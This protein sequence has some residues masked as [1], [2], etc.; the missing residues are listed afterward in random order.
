MSASMTPC[1][2]SWIRRASALLVALSAVTRA[3][4]AEALPPT[5]KRAVPEFGSLILGEFGVVIV[6]GAKPGAYGRILPAEVLY[7]ESRRDSAGPAYGAWAAPVE[8]WASER[9]RGV[10][11][12]PAML[13]G[14]IQGSRWAVLMGA[15]VNTITLNELRT[16]E[17]VTRGAKRGFGVLSPRFQVRLVARRVREIFYGAL[18]A[19]FQRQWLWGLDDV[20][21]VQIGIAFGFGDKLR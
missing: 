21:L 2:I 10:G 17:G 7:G 1:S 15:G 3:A 9:A 19:D 20:T 14:G 16:A 8:L 13:L 6:P 5:S 18:I 11:L 12:L 4:R